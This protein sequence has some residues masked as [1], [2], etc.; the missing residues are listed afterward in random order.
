[1]IL[2]THTKLLQNETLCYQATSSTRL[3]RSAVNWTNV[4]A[5]LPLSTVGT[6]H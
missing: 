6:R 1:V 5:V 2:L 3:R 4:I